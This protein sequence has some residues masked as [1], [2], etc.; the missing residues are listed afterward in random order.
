MDDIPSVEDTVDINVF[1]YDIDL[2]DGA[3]VGEFAQ[4]SIKM[5]EK[6]DQLIQYNSHIC[7]VDTIHALFKGFCCPTC[8]KYFQKTRKLG[9]SLGQM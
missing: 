6:N 7:Y 2:V 5:Y 8:D 9:A 1:K 4:R 3:L